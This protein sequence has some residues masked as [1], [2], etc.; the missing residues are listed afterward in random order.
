[1]PKHAQTCLSRFR[2]RRGSIRLGGGV[3]GWGDRGDKQWCGQE[4]EERDS[5]YTHGIVSEK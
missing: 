2:R 4:R 3:P 1:M 5:T